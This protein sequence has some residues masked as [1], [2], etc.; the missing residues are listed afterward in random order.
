MVCPLCSRNP[1][2]KPAPQDRRAVGNSDPAVTDD[3]AGANGRRMHV[4]IAV[5]QVDGYAVVLC[6][7]RPNNTPTAKPSKAQRG[8]V[9][10]L[11]KSQA[12]GLIGIGEGWWVS[13]VGETGRIQ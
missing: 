2:G 7:I 10:V 8:P 1:K 13:G 12:S 4:V 9:T 3:K 11:S 6:H 5:R